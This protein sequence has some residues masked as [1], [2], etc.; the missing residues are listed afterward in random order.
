MS[1]FHSSVRGYPPVLPALFVE[2]TV[3]SPWIALEPCQVYDH[4]RVYF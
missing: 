2:E 3:L 1:T 4:M